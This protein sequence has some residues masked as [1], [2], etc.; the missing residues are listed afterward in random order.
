MD[1]S[2][3][4]MS[5]ALAEVEISGNRASSKVF[6]DGKYLGK[7]DQLSGG[8]HKTNLMQGMHDIQLVGPGG[9]K[10]ERNVLVAAGKTFKFQYDFEGCRATRLLPDPRR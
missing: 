7:V 5:V 9:Q 1:L 6:V 8:H 2:F 10:A 3:C 4:S